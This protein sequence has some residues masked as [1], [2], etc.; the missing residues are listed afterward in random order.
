MGK[1]HATV[2]RALDALG[3]LNDLHTAETLLRAHAADDARAWFAV[4]WV[5]ARQ[6]PAFARAA[7]TLSRLAR[8]HRQPLPWR[9]LPHVKH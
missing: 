6:E 7:A 2:C 1:P 5:R 9:R 8:Q 3:E 4:G